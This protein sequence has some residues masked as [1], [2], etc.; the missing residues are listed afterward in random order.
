MPSD[1]SVTLLLA[2][3]RDGSPETCADATARLWARYFGSLVELA[4]TRLP[5]AARRAADE[6]DVALSALDSLFRGEA[7]GRFPRLDNREALW[8]VLATITLRKV[9]DAIAHEGRQKRGAGRTPAS[10][11]GLDAVLAHEPSPDMAA[12]L[13]D[14][15][16]HLLE[17]LGDDRLR[18]LAL[19]KIEGHTEEEMA[20]KLGVSPRTVRRKLDLVRRLWEREVG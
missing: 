9:H 11:V 20:A 10:A 3:L 13:A 6:E 15:I 4:R 16:G 7:A 14:L 17:R 5:G 2:R 8:R 1:G 19:L 12:Q 18:R